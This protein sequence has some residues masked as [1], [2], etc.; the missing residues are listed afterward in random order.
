MLKIIPTNQLEPYRD[1]YYA[2]MDKYFVNN[3]FRCTPDSYKNWR[4]SPF[5]IALCGVEDE[6]TLSYISF[7]ITNRQGME[8]YIKG[9]TPEW[10][11]L[12]YPQGSNEEACLLWSTLIFENKHHAPYL[13]HSAFH[14]IASV[15]RAWKINISTVF[16]CAYTKTSER[17]MRR[18]KFKKVGMYE[19]KYPIMAI[20]VTDNAYLKAFIPYIHIESTPPWAGKTAHPIPDMTPKPKA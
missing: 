10:D 17:L 15:M 3:D 12:P 2:L 8:L 4:V 6:K 7:L 20:K 14:E 19:N 5:C 1:R 18:Y 13:I 16:A 9:Q 11:I